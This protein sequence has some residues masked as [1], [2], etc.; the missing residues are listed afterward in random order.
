MTLTSLQSQDK[1]RS[2][3]WRFFWGTLIFKVLLSAVFPITGDE[4]LFVQWGK[5][6]DWGYYDHP[7][8]IGWWLSVLM[9]LGDARGVIRALT[10]LTTHVLALGIVDLLRRYDPDPA[11]PWLGG[12]IYLLLPWTWLFF[13]VTTDTPVILFMAL[14]AW[15]FLQGLS[16]DHIGWFWAAGL[17]LGLA[18]LSKYFAV[19]LGLGFATAVL[20]DGRQRIFRLL[21]LATPGL[22]CAAYNLGFNA[23]HGWP[24]IMFNLYARHETSGWNLQSPLTYLFMMGYLL[25]PW[26]VWWAARS[27]HPLHPPVGTV[28]KNQWALWLWCVPLAIFGL[29]SLRREIG[30]HWVLGFVPMFLVWASLR[31]SSI[32][33]HKAIRYSLWLNLPHLMLILALLVWPLGF[34][35]NEGFREKAVFFRYSSQ[36]TKQVVSTLPADSMLMGTGYSTASILAYHHGQ[37][38]PVFGMGSKYARQDDLWTDFRSLQG[39]SIR[40]FDRNA[41]DMAQYLPFFEKVTPGRVEY[42]GDTYEFLDGQG[43]R[44]EVYKEQILNEIHRK[45]FNIPD[46]LPLLGNPFCERY[47]YEDC[48]PQKGVSRLGR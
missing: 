16:K 28:F 12:S 4:A 21:A 41:M 11:K 5:R 13:L 17:A 27:N 48:Q 2:W 35:S 8:M 46:F 25:T 47:G 30:L 15:C 40:I 36:I 3:F 20:L 39:R 14:A 10:V 44:Y 24:N 29:I 7:P 33:L 31:I 18:F 34:I 1:A 32:R 42:M 38:V 6:P 26:L 22:L 37:Y 23:S 19:L 45:Y 9:V 43:F